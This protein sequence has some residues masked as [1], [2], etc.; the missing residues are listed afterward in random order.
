MLQSKIIFII[1]LLTSMMF[2]EN[3]YHRKLEKIAEA[4]HLAGM[5]V[6]V[7]KNNSIKD[8]FHYGYSNLENKKALND[9]SMFRIASISK[10]FTATAIMLLYEKKL[11]NLDE[12]ISNYLGYK[13]SNPYYPDKKITCRML[14]SHTSGLQDSTAYENFLMTSYRQTP[15]PKMHELFTEGEQ[16][17]AKNIFMNKEPGTYFTYCN[18]NFAVIGTIVEKISRERFDIYVKKNIL[19][20][21]GIKG[22]FNV[23]DIEKIENIA[24]LYRNSEPQADNYSSIRP[25]PRD[26]SKYTPGDNAII[27]GPQGGLRISAKELCKWMMMLMNYG[28]LENVK[29]LDSA[30]VAL[31]ENVQWKYNG[32]NGDNYHNLFNAW[33]LGI[34]LLTNTPGGDM[35]FKEMNMCGHAGDAYGLI[36]DMYFDKEKKTGIIFITNGY[37]TEKEFENDTNSAFYKPEKEV[38]DL[39]WEKFMRK[40][41]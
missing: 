26:L 16:F 30:T 37:R 12:D 28:T 40:R 27:F 3:N 38:F 11:L 39:V 19:N 9:S 15:P 31:M 35:V 8:I 10:T 4:N 32:N 1:I 13:V 23:Q 36:S 22:S 7:V 17:Y 33:G 34:H 6:V 14:L 18:L 5:S 41:N 21:L 20:P 25:I 29:I 2:D 24:V